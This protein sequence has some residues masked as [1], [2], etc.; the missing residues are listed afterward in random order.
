MVTQHNTKYN[1]P[2]NV[3]NESCAQNYFPIILSSWVR[4]SIQTTQPKNIH[5]FKKKL[6]MTKIQQK[7]RPQNPLSASALP[8][9]VKNQTFI[10]I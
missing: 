8:T 5:T 4:F 6:S 7:H 10:D 2:L 1:K 9:H 3:S